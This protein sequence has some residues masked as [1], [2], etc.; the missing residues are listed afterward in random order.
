MGSTTSKTIIN[1]I[2]N[3][4]SAAAILSSS[5]VNK[6]V[7]SLSQVIDQNC[8]ASDDLVLKIKNSASCLL[9]IDKYGA[10]SACP[11][12]F[13]CAIVG[14]SQNMI[15]NITVNTQQTGDISTTFAATL[16]T[17]IDNY[18]SEK[19]DAIAQFLQTAN[20]GGKTD[21]WIEN[22]VINKIAPTI[23]AKLV[24]DCVTD[25][26]QTQLIQQG[27]VGGI[28]YNCSQNQA[29]TLM[30]TVIQ[31]NSATAAATADVSND[32]KNKLLEDKSTIG[33]LATAFSNVATAGII[34]FAI[35]MCIVIVVV[36]VG[37][38]K[39]LKSSKG[40]T[41]NREGY[42]NKNNVVNTSLKPMVPSPI[43]SSV[44]PVKRSALNAN[45]FRGADVTHSS[46]RQRASAHR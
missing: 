16:K 10:E 33:Q 15:A 3:E 17:V 1:S 5:L 2:V 24:N 44:E 39:I 21:T 40:V 7:V 30:S 8:E 43:T 20:P 13:A 4:F 6:V 32:I 22:K 28:I 45:L 27:G 9:C 25:V 38:P 26:A 14:V 12:C 31:N 23:D 37:A 36:I 11:V 35:V 41:V 34:A 42:T 46:Y 19:S 29:V 18:Q